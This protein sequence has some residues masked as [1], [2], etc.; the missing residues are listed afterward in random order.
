MCEGPFKISRPD[1]DQSG[2]SYHFETSICSQ[3][4]DFEIMVF[5]IGS[6]SSLHS[7][8]VSNFGVYSWM[9]SSSDNA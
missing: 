5:A 7:N 3:L 1:L 9:I 8:A 2:A 6:H 4:P